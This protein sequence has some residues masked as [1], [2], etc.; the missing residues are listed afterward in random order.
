MVYDA[1]LVL[2][3]FERLAELVVSQLHAAGLLRRGG[4]A[5]SASGKFRP[6]TCEYIGGAKG[7]RTP[8]STRENAALT[9]VS[10]PPRS[11]SVALVTCG[12]VLG[13]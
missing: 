3:T 8:A 4:A 12:F 5:A 6:L 9:A 1:L 10:F 7:I 2:I 11:D 13:S